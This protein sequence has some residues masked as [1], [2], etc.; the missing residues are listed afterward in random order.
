MADSPTLADA[1]AAFARL[2]DTLDTLG[3]NDDLD[4]ADTDGPCEARSGARDDIATVQR[5]LDMVAAG[6]PHV[7]TLRTTAQAFADDLR[8]GLADGTYDNGA[9]LPGIDAAIIATAR[10]SFAAAPLPTL[11]AEPV[12]YGVGYRVSGGSGGT[13]FDTWSDAAAWLTAQALRLSPDKPAEFP[14][15]APTGPT[16]WARNGVTFSAYLIGGR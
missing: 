11:G 1:L 12:R 4:P 16:S 5:A 2:A 6:A 7:E 14:A 10:L 3:V 9:A 8:D 13:S 15:D